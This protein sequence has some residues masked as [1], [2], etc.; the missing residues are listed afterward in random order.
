MAVV[1]S[2]LFWTGQ[3]GGWE[4]GG[5]RE[6]VSI[7]HVYTDDPRDGPAV[8]L[9]NGMP[10]GLGD[11]Y[12]GIGNDSD[13]ECK[14]VSMVPNRMPDTRLK[15]EVVAKW[16]QLPVGGGGEF[17]GMNNKGEPTDDPLD[18]MDG[19]ELTYAQFQEP[20]AKAWYRSG[21]KGEAAKMRTAGKQYPVT[22]SAMVPYDPPPERDNSRL[23]LRLT[24]T[25]QKFPSTDADAYQDAVNSDAFTINK[26]FQGF[27][28]VFPKWNA[29]MQ[30]IGGAWQLVNGVSR[31]RVTY[32][33]HKWPRRIGWREEVLDRGHSRRQMA[34]DTNPQGKVIS[35]SGQVTGAPQWGPNQAPNGM[36]IT[37]ALSFDGDG[38]PIAPGD[39]EVWILWS[40]YPELAYAP[41]NL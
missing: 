23:V 19:I 32:E 17:K 26:P 28:M 5:K 4:L 34:G 35:A 18:E 39:P 22:N 38:Q 6:Y 16:Q 3:T 14:L 2:K 21:F 29:K 12:S 15:W 27:N 1:Q 9:T 24:K 33:I 40:Y 13:P 36:V 20:V 37:E 8:V 41:L 25:M 30:N 10:W 31:W 7:H 11:D